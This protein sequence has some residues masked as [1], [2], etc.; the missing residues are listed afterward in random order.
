[1]MIIVLGESG[2]EECICILKTLKWNNNEDNNQTIEAS[3]DN[4]N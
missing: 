2:Y 3:N 1:M 4:E